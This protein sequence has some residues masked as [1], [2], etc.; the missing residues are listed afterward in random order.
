MKAFRPFVAPEG[1]VSFTV[2]LYHSDKSSAPA[3]DVDLQALMPAGLAYEPG[4]IGLWQ[5]P[6][7]IL[8]ERH[9]DGTLTPSVWTGTVT[10]RPLSASMP[11]LCPRRAS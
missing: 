4:S 8:I 2:V 5:D 6:S 7:S 3:F 1:R 11:Q 9:S 10:K